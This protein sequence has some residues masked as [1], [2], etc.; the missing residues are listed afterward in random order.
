M[1]TRANA[2]TAHPRASGLYVDIDDGIVTV[3]AH[4][5]PLHAV[6][7]KLAEHGGLLVLTQDRLDQRVTV[8]L[9]SLTL[10]ATLQELLHG[11]SFVLVD[12]RQATDA[13]QDGR[14]TLWILSKELSRTDANVSVVSIEDSHEYARREEQKSLDELS[15]ALTD[16]DSN[17]RLDAVSELGGHIDDEQAALML[18][19]VASHDEH[20]SVRAEALHAIGGGRAD[21]HNPVFTRALTDR[22]AGVRKAAISAV[23]NIGA[24]NSIQILALALKD[25]DAS[26]RATAVDAIGEI[27]GDNALRLIKSALT[28]ESAVVRE[29]ATE[30]LMQTPSSRMPTEDTRMTDLAR[31]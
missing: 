21:I 3:R 28:D 17:N 5:A 24:E 2:L 11:T 29:A 20:P 1:H 6:I 13:R 18:A 30:Q 19:S 23:E 14:G 10:R 15:A 27:G 31:W 7:E 22:D 9:Q 16:H 4:D 25:R 26:V 8:E 12:A